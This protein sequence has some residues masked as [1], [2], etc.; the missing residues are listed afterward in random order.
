MAAGRFG[1][2]SL[3]IALAGR[4]AAQGR[5]TVT[6]GTLPDD[7]ATFAVLV[8]GAVLLVGALSSPRP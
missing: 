4:F 6:I 3:A 7:T 8:L 2:V 5:K 1:L